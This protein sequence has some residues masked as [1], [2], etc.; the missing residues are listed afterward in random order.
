MYSHSSIRIMKQTQYFCNNSSQSSSFI[1]KHFILKTINSIIND[2]INSINLTVNN[3]V[4]SYCRTIDRTINM[5]VNI[6][7]SPFVNCIS[8]PFYRLSSCPEKDNIRY[9]QYCAQTTVPNFFECHV[10]ASQI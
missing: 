1:R 8:H 7:W 5:S 9:C 4:K 10:L 6:F 2:L 3:C